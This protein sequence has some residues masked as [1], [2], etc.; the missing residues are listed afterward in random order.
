M[1]E[2]T[3]E[4]RLPAVVTAPETSP[5]D[6]SRELTAAEKAAVILVALGPEVAGGML[7][8]MGDAG[9]RKFARAVSGMSQIP[10]ERVAEVVNEF[11]I[12]MGDELTVRG[13]AEAARKFLGQV[14]DSDALTRIMEDLDGRGGKSLWTKLSEAADA[15]FANW[16]QTEHPQV[17]AV[18]LTKLRPVQAARLLER[19]DRAFAREVVLRMGRVPR[20]DP[21][22]MEKVG[23][24]IERDFLSAMERTQGARKPTE[25]IAGLLNH[26][27]GS[28]REVFLQHLD[29]AEP[30]LAQEVQRVM[31]TFGDIADRVSARDIAKV[32][33]AVDEP[34]LLAAL[35]TAREARDPAAEFILGNI[36]SR[37]AERLIEDME[38]MADI[39]QK[40]GEAAQGEVVQTIQA[41]A[42]AGDIKLIELETGEE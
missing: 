19:L 3:A 25:I 14:M 41:L 42:K 36:S 35:K 13:G 11:L 21:S 6:G 12:A 40:E 9:I 28:A 18:I 26:V 17:V 39:R 2:S 29:E 4:A 22:A 5:A 16:L 23:E 24:V 38:M 31:F 34:V 1:T 30:K 37:L 32:V 10:H 8:D 33:K 20:I 15:P 7:R 27:S